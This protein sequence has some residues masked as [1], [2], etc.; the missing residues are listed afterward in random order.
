MSSCTFCGIVAGR[1][2]AR[3]VREWPDVIAFRD[4]NELVPNG[5]ILVIPRRHVVDATEDPQLSGRVMTCMSLL[6]QEFEYSNFIFNNGRPATQS[7]FHMH[8][9]LLLRKPQD[10]LMVPWGTTG[11]P[12]APHACTRAL[13]AEEQRALLAHRLEALTTLANAF[14]IKPEET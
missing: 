4:K 1:K 8:G 5:H 14:D 12:H 6:A 13:V 10:G 2:S 11:N 3:M 9:H 7:E